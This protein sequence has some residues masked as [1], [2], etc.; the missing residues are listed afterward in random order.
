MTSRLAVY[1]G[2][3]LALGERSLA[4]LVEDREPRHVLDEVWSDGIKYVLGTAQWR[5]A[6]RSVQITADPDIDTSFGYQHAFAKPT[7]LI[8]TTGMYGDESLQAPLTQY[9]YEGGYFYSDMDPLYL[10]YVSD[11]ALYG[12]DLSNWP[13]NFT[14]YAELY[15]ASKIMLRLTG[16]KA[17]PDRVEKK[18]RAARL[19]AA[20]TDAMEDPTSFAD[21]GTWVRSRGGWWRGD[22]GSRSRLIG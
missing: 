10:R 6:T 5:F 19:Q 18:L 13:A 22:R 8:R 15:L 9:R 21:P 17:D 12:G 11:D 4:S 3:L 2:A 14:A 20:A 1:N 16:A 7:D